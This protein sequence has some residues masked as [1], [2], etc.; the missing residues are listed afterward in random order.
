RGNGNL[1][2]AII[3]TAVSATAPSAATATIV[4]AHFISAVLSKRRWRQVNAHCRW[5]PHN[6][7]DC[8]WLS[9]DGFFVASELGAKVTAA[10]PLRGHRANPGR[11]TSPSRSCG[12]WH[13]PS[14]PSER[15]A[16]PPDGSSAK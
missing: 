8:F 16:K 5:S 1:L 3:T 13:E 10:S 11:A 4:I 9:S 15:P 2:D 6:A 12:E 14:R 7:Q